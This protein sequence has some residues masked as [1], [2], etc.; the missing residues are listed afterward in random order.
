MQIENFI[1]N[2]NNRILILEDGSKVFCKDKSSAISK[3][4]KIFKDKIIDEAAEAL[5]LDPD[6][7]IYNE[8][9]FRLIAHITSDNWIDSLG[10][11]IN[12]ELPNYIKKSHPDYELFSGY[13][14]RAK[15]IYD[16]FIIHQ[17]KPFKMIEKRS[18]QVDQ[19]SLFI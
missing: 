12:R 18:K 7:D 10:F 13:Y 2:E 3:V 4:T 19:L 11:I 14:S 15:T 9:Y 1:Y 6:R 17:N 16:H 5:N 8:L